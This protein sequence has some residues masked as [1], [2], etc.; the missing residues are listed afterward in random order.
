MGGSERSL[1]VKVFFFRMSPVLVS[2]SFLIITY[3]KMPCQAPARGVTRDFDFRPH[4]WR[5]LWGFAKY[6]AVNQFVSFRCEGWWGPFDS[7]T[8]VAGG[9]KGRVLRGVCRGHT[10]L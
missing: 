10:A 1:Y 4:F 8:S 7:I 2:C 5:Q 6:S 3:D 9:E